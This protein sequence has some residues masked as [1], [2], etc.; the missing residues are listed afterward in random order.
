MKK[1]FLFLATLGVMA[2]AAAP[3]LAEDG[4]PQ[5]SWWGGWQTSHKDNVLSPDT[6]INFGKHGS[7]DSEYCVDT[8]MADQNCSTGGTASG[9]F[10]AGY[11]NAAGMSNPGCTTT[12]PDGSTNNEQ[13]GRNPDCDSLGGFYVGTTTTTGG[14][15][16]V[17]PV[18][19]GAGCVGK[20]GLS[21]TGVGLADEPASGEPAPPGSSGD[22]E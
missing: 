3:A 11:V 12:N 2:L 19:N 21:A 22:V 16:T 13:S 10:F 17:C 4:T 9:V 8:N 20:P 5:P 18:T 6:W 1:V 7:G 15:D 14:L